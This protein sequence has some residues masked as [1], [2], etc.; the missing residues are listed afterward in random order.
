MTVNGK[1]AFAKLLSTLKITKAKS[2]LLNLEFIVFYVN[3]RT[4]S[5]P[6]Y[7]QVRWQPGDACERVWFITHVLSKGVVSQYVLCVHGI[8]FPFNEGRKGDAQIN[9]LLPT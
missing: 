9:S 7:S 4:G 1:E 5:L 2:I 8:G 6:T 3:N